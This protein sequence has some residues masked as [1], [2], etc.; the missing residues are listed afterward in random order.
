MIIKNRI[1][2]CQQNEVLHPKKNAH[3]SQPP[4][5]SKPGVLN[6]SPPKSKT[7]FPLNPMSSDINEDKLAHQGHRYF[8][9]S[10]KFR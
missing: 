7:P 1:Y 2:K 10:S 4:F 9:V 3:C 6:I 5:T 8:V